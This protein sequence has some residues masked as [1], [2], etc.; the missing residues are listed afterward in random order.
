MR[1]N[2]RFKS[3]VVAL[4]AIT[5]LILPFTSDVNWVSRSFWISSVL[6]AFLSVAFSCK[7]QRF[8][9]AFLCAKDLWEFKMF[10]HDGPQWKPAKPKLSVVL[11]L[12]ATKHFCDLALILYVLGLG[13][14]L[15]GLS[16]GDP[17]KAAA[18]NSSRNIFI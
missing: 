17:D 13:V 1:A 10:L 6:S 8:V 18:P 3:T 5:S 14:Y 9:G 12:S 11:L 16:Q 7:H 15:G 4:I 2:V